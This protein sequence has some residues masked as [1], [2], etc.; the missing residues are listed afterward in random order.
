MRSGFNQMFARFT[1]RLA[2][3]IDL[4]PAIKPTRLY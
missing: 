2:R 4:M 3:R 1:D